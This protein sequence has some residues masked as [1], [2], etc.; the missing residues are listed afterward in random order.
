MRQFITYFLNAKTQKEVVNL[1]HITLQS[2]R[3]PSDVL[4]WSQMLQ[5]T[6]ASMQDQPR[7]SIGFARELIWQWRNEIWQNKEA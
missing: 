7:S 1:L 5:N 2:G 3:E 6:I 4:A